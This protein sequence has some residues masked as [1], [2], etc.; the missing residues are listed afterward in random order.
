MV[1][2][3]FDLAHLLLQSFFKKTRAPN[4]KTQ[5]LFNTIKA[6]HHISHLLLMCY[7]I[8]YRLLHALSQP[9]EALELALKLLL[10]LC[11]D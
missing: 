1:C 4:V 9:H 3:L 5:R 2:V 10:H 7:K 6:L 8:M 11:L